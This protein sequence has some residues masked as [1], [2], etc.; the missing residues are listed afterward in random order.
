[1]ACILKCPAAKPRSAL[2]YRPNA[3]ERFRTVWVV[4]EQGSTVRTTCLTVPEPLLALTH[5]ENFEGPVGSRDS[6]HGS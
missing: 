2:D 4:S 5:K 3:S 1:M 6:S